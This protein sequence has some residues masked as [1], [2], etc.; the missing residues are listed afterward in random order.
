M[1]AADWTPWLK[2]GREHTYLP[3]LAQKWAVGAVPTSLVKEAG[4]LQ[5]RAPLRKYEWRTEGISA[6]T[7][8]TSYCVLS[9]YSFWGISVCASRRKPC[10]HNL[11]KTGQKLSPHLPEPACLLR[12]YSFMYSFVR[13]FIHAD[14]FTG[15]CLGQG[16]MAQPLKSVHLEPKS[17][18]WQLLATNF[19]FC[20]SSSSMVTVSTKQECL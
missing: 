9:T 18:L 17:Q 2:G 4:S 16:W 14:S 20:A 1:R 8:P 7:G 11:S 10:L 13:S 3:V 15:G 19:M 5:R 12:S 6:V